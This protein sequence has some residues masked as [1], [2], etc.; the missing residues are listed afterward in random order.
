MSSPRRHSWRRPQV[1]PH[2]GSEWFYER[3][4]EGVDGVPDSD[5]TYLLANRLG[6]PGR[7]SHWV[8][9]CLCG[10]PQRP[11][12]GGMR[13]GRSPNVSIGRFFE[14][15]ARTQRIDDVTK[16]KLTREAW[17]PIWEDLAC[18]DKI[19]NDQLRRKRLRRQ[20]AENVPVS[21][22]TPAGSGK[23][24]LV[25][26]VQRCAST[27]DRA[28]QAVAAIVEIW[29]SNLVELRPIET[30]LGWVG[31][32]GAP[33]KRCEIRFGRLCELFFDH[34]RVRLTKKKK[35]LFA[36]P[37]N[38]KAS[39][40]HDRKTP[41]ST[42][43]DLSCPECGGSYFTE[44][45]CQRYLSGMPSSWPGG[46]I[47]PM[48]DAAPIHTLVC[49]C[50]FALNV[51]SRA[52]PK[53]LRDSFAASFEK[54][55][56]YRHPDAFEQRLQN[57]AAELVNDG[58]LAR[59]SEEVRRVVYLAEIARR[60]A[61][62]SQ[63]TP[64]TAVPSSIGNSDEPVGLPIQETAFP[65][66]C[67]ILKLS[68]KLKIPVTEAGRMVEAVFNAIEDAVA[69]GKRVEIRGFGSFLPCDRKAWKGRNPKNREPFEV[70][71]TRTAHFKPSRQL[72][73]LVNQG[74]SD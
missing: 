6:L 66:G 34:R 41:A 38:A 23:D 51:Q 47:T 73:A 42:S 64:G 3:R 59:Y 14:D 50:G 8:L 19:F 25:V 71:R 72:T 2:C 7:G 28:R 74:L 62:A 1:C 52:I 35:G 49:L 27:F 48:S 44:V 65:K 70:G 10:M 13:G 37:D 61:K 43:P 68:A 36:P 45:A 46:N 21:E 20:A 60:P 53:P 67:L 22:R 56:A 33:Y 24:L 17:K 57:V 11:L 5:L 40:N 29:K 16:D 58:D 9:I 15:F 12:I 4:F 39:N 31:T 30:P 32:R 26:A 69:S 63:P 55:R 18:L 54:A